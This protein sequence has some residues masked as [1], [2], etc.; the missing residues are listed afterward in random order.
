MPIPELKRF[1]D[2]WIRDNL[3]DFVLDSPYFIE[4]AFIPPLTILNLRLRSGEWRPAMN[5]GTTWTPF[6]ISRPKYDELVKQLLSRRPNTL[7]HADYPRSIQTE[8]DW[9]IFLAE[10]L[11]GIPAEEHKEIVQKVRAMEQARDEVMFHGKRGDLSKLAEAAIQANI[12]WDYFRDRYKQHGSRHVDREDR[13]RHARPNIQGPSKIPLSILFFH[14]AAYLIMIFNI[15]VYDDWQRIWNLLI[16]ILLV[17]VSFFFLFI[18]KSEIAFRVILLSASLVL[19]GLILKMP[20]VLRPV[21]DIVRSIENNITQVRYA[22]I[23]HRTEE[24]KTAHLNYFRTV[25]KEP[26]KVVN[27]SGCYII[28]EN[29]LCLSLCASECNGEISDY[30]KTRLIGRYIKV[31]LADRYSP[32]YP[33]SGSRNYYPNQSSKETADFKTGSA[34]EYGDITSFVF[35]GEELLNTTVMKMYDPQIPEIRISDITKIARKMALD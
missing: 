1:N 9:T 28:L 8:D 24:T 10:L 6:E 15:S 29:A 14:A 26:Q 19:P 4:R 21:V 2:E 20:P 5:P 35:L 13:A 23:Y 27:I 22:R 7:K 17:V 30:L 31:V 11:D 25:F 16:W 3:A 32:Y 12:E 33:Y 18:S 34:K